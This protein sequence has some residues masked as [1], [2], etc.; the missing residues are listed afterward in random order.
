MSVLRIDFIARLICGVC[1]MILVAGVAHA[2]TSDLVVRSALR[3]CADPANMPFSNKERA[4]FENKVAELLAKKL[5]VPL[6]YTWFPQATGF[7]RSTLRARKCDL[8]IGY[9]Q[10]HELVQNTNHYY[11]SAYVL[12]YPEHSG[13][14]GV[15]SLSDPRLKDKRIGVVAGTPPA[16]VMALNGLLGN[17]RPFQLM[18]DRRHFSPAE[19]MIEEIASGQLDAGLLWGPIGGYFA[20]QSKKP[21]TV[22]PLVKEQAG[23]RLAYRITM[24]V[25][26]NER[27]W[28]RQLNRL[29][30]KNQDEIN[31]ILHGF[32]VPLLDEQNNAIVPN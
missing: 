4:G 23:P 5:D 15:D 28:K 24:G 10:G 30:A 19:R 17:V 22:V 32:G 3:V 20:K 26:P 29:I 21:L 1:A 9:A 7:V 6:I 2:Q 13:L 12:I 25:R 11:R 27:D 31:A 8:I 16:T 18:V 14:E